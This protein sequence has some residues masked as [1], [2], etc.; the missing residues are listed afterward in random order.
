MESSRS[1]SRYT[2][3]NP[4]TD[5]LSPHWL[6]AAETIDIEADGMVKGKAAIQVFKQFPYL[7]K[8]PYWGIR[9]SPLVQHQKGVFP[10]PQ[11]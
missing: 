11:L 2:L 3:P 7:K 10:Y 6:G 5:T 4:S 1:L 9:P 8:K